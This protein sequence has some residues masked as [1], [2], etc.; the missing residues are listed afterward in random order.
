M[1]LPPPPF[2]AEVISPI[3]TPKQTNNGVGQSASEADSPI[4][5]RP[6][7]NILRPHLYQSSEEAKKEKEYR[8]KFYRRSP[9]THRKKKHPPHA[10]SQ[11]YCV[12]RMTSTRTNSQEKPSPGVSSAPT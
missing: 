11:D 12:F 4:V 9:H 10:K 1:D 3:S 7:R 6:H 8:K 2:S 5:E